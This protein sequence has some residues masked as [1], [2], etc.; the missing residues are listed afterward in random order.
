MKNGL[1]VCRLSGGYVVLL[2]G[3]MMKL[4]NGERWWNVGLG[5]RSEKSFRLV[6]LFSLLF[7]A[8]YLALNLSPEADL[9]FLSH[10]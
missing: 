10:L 2:A 9:G 8:R 4:S 6:F 7:L 5:T 1:M 3:M